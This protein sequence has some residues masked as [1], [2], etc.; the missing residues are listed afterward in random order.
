MLPVMCGDHPVLLPVLLGGRRQTG[1][2]GSPSIFM[3][4]I[5][6]HP[7]QYFMSVTI[8]KKFSAH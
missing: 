6:F 8:K 3:P 2:P 1:E 5:N 4:D 7:F